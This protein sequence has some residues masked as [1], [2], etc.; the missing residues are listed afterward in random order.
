MPEAKEGET[1]EEGKKVYSVWVSAIQDCAKEESQT[2]SIAAAKFHW[3]SLDRHQT[4]L[5]HC[6]LSW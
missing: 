2:A 3:L 5:H 1:E 6:L 4:G